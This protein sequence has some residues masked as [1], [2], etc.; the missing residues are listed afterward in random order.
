[1]FSCLLQGGPCR[2]MGVRG[3][4]SS[5][6]L[7]AVGKG[8]KL[9]PPPGLTKT[10]SV[11]GRVMWKRLASPHPLASPASLASREGQGVSGKGAGQ[12]ASRRGG[13]SR[14]KG[15]MAAT[16]WHLLYGQGEEEE[17]GMAKLSAGQLFHLEGH[18]EEAEEAFCPGLSAPASPPLMTALFRDP[19][20]SDDYC[21]VLRS[22]GCHLHP[23]QPDS[24]KQSKKNPAVESQMAVR[25]CLP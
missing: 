19:M 16:S 5:K 20:T 2:Q 18:R 24:H 23:S 15:T 11:L 9:Q 8:L 22:T 17:A 10:A 7:M 25:G 13:G 3:E 4:S 6:W 12:H 14:G 1:M 21:S